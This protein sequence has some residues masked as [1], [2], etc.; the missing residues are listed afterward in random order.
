MN[1]AGKELGKVDLEGKI[2]RCIGP[3]VLKKALLTD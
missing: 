1:H 2:P 3:F